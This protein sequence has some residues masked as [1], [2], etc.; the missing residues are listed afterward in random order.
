MIF[1][2]IVIF[3]VA[4]FLHRSKTNNREIVKP[5]I[6]NRYESKRLKIILQ[7]VTTDND[8]NSVTTDVATDNVVTTDNDVKRDFGAKLEAL[9]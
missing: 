7:R 8:V 2:K 4:R 3:G 9:N 5:L 6:P 1:A